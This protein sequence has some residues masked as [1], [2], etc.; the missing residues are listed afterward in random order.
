MEPS[1]QSIFEHAITPERNL[2]PLHL[3]S[4]LTPCSLFSAQQPDRTFKNVSQIV[5]PSARN[6]SVIPMVHGVKSSLSA[7]ETSPV[8]PGHSS[9]SSFLPPFPCGWHAPVFLDKCVTRLFPTSGSLPLGFPPSLPRLYFLV[10]LPG[11]CYISR[12]SALS[13]ASLTT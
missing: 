13:P 11:S 12:S 2:T 5:P 9:S 3:F 4:L 10:W 8:S 6:P 7:P 1:P